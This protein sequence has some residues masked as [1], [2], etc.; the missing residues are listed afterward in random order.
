MSFRITY[1]GCKIEETVH[2]LGH[3]FRLYGLDDHLLLLDR[4]GWGGL[5]GLDGVIRI[6]IN[7]SAG[8]RRS[9]QE[10][11]KRAEEE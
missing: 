11:C 1:C 6:D 10:D 3:I 4:L 2:G 9:D 7:R 5:D 8:N